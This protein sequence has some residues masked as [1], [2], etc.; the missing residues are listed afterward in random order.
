MSKRK[1]FIIDQNISPELKK[2]L[3][4]GTRTT[5]ECGLPPQAPDPD[6]LELCQQEHATLIT[7]DFGLPKHLDKYQKSHN[8]CGYGLFIV[9]IEQHRQIDLFKRMRTGKPKLKQPRDPVFRFEDAGDDNLLVDL[10]AD[11]PKVVE[12]CSCKWLD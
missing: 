9:P 12:L 4:A 5:T 3:A 2:F 6:A 10:R 1:H 11:Q 7:A 8:T